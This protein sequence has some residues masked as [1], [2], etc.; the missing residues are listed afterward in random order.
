MS[1]YWEPRR[2]LDEALLNFCTL[3]KQMAAGVALIIS[4]LIQ[5]RDVS[6]LCRSTGKCSIFLADLPQTPLVWL[7]AAWWVDV[8]A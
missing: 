5:L 1:L 6:G 2:P 4:R 3:S 8:E 7:Q